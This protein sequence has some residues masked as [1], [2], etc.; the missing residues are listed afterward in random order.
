MENNE[1]LLAG[2]TDQ[3]KGAYLG[4]IASIATADRQASQEELDSLAELC[5]AARLNDQQKPGCITSSLQHFRRRVEAMSQ[6]IENQRSQI[7]I[8]HRHDCL[9]KIR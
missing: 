1:P 9:C 7:F 4:A 3:E 8:G 5:D 2:H 6:Y